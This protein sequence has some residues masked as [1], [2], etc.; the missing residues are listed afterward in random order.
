[1][2]RPQ[3]G[4][5]EIELMRMAIDQARMAEEFGEV[6]VGCVIA[7][8]KEIL[9]ATHNRRI[10]DDDPTAHAEIVAIRLAAEKIGDWRLQ[11][12]DMA[13]TLEPCCMCAGA[14]VLARIEKLIYGAPDPKAGAVDTLYRICND[15]RLNHNPEVIGGVM[16]GECGEILSSFF[17]IRR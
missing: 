10:L 15:T 5:S 7:R 6:P 3:T 8:G 1:L 11:G 12:C 14:I 17:R 16:A 13:V 9:A 2:S 4:Y